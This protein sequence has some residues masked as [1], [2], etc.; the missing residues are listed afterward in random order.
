VKR[1]CLLLALPALL[2]ALAVARPAEGPP[3]GATADRIA[4]L[5]AALDDD[6][7][8][9][10]EE[11]TAELRR[12]GAPAEA[13]LRKALAESPSAEVRRRARDLLRSVRTRFEAESA[14]WSWIYADIAH[15]QTF[16]ALGADLRSLRL[17]VAR[18]NATA[19]AAPLEVEIRDPTL[20]ATYARG[21]VP[22]EEAGREFAWREVRWRHRAPLTPGGRYVLFFHSQ[23]TSHRA[24]WLVNEI[25]SD[26]YPDGE[27]LG[28][29]FDFFFRLEFGNGRT[30]HV[31]P[32]KETTKAVPI[33]SG[34]RG[35]TER[36]GPLTLVGFGRVPPGTDVPRRAS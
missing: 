8:A 7:F 34:D 18:L 24:P 25:Y 2:S 15:G 14:G 27:H 22:V 28:Y 11:A 29:A 3:E 26:L 6:D 30:L 23:D 31:G 12:V 32:A 36:K 17:R 21:L 19:P 33:S 35:G 9:A 20:K 13:A 5:I 10:R 4:R 16:R 1:T